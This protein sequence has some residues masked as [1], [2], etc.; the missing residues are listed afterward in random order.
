MIDKELRRRGIGGSDV[1][2][3]LGISPFATSLDVWRRKVLGDETPES[4]P[5]RWG[6][7]LEPVVRAEAARRLNVVGV[8]PAGIVTGSEPQLIANVDG[9]VGADAVLECKTAR[10]DEGWGVEGTDEIPDHYL[11]QTAWYLMVTA[12]SLAHVAVLIGGSDF[13]M[14]R[15]ARN[16]E[17]EHKILSRCIA[18]WRRHVETEEPPPPTNVAD[19]RA[20][21]RREIAGRS[22]PLTDDL[23]AAIETRQRAK[24][25]IRLQETL[26]ERA[27]VEIMRA[28]SDAEYI[29]D[30]HGSPVVTWKLQ[31]RKGYTVAPSEARVLRVT[32]WADK[33]LEVKQ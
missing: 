30:E 4:E 7:L 25:R 18:W 2:P 5:M 29:V 16:M 17:L 11:T 24:E 15:V 26:V 13:R 1:A 10:S 12:R 28:L 6:T 22:V 33:L 8:D 31:Q 23:R 9:L 19:C 14:Y 20:L 32:K 3:I 21:W 27:D